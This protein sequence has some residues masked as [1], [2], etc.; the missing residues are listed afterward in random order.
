MRLLL[1]TL[2]IFSLLCSV[3]C[4]SVMAK[5]S[6]SDNVYTSSGEQKVQFDSFSESEF[7]ENIFQ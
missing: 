2:I 7:A 1:N 4:S 6:V 3:F 5:E